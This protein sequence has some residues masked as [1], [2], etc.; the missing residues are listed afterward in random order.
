MKKSGS[1]R[2]EEKEGEMRRKRGGGRREGGVREVG[3]E[4]NG[5]KG[6]GK[7]RRMERRGEGEE[8]GGERKED[9]EVDEVRRREMI[10]FG[11]ILNVLNKLR[12]FF[13]LETVGITEALGRVWAVVL[14]KWFSNTRLEI[15]SRVLLGSLFEMTKEGKV[16]MR[17]CL[18]VV[19]VFIFEI[20][21]ENE[22]LTQDTLNL[23]Y[24]LFLV[25]LTYL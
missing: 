21:Q 24:P 23:F 1:R 6:E 13:M 18:K 11:L 22:A 14:R 8:E 17:N 9:E 4:K 10:E 15:K 7:G 16:L 19:N 5:K 2:R 20:Q 12:R 3:S 25:L